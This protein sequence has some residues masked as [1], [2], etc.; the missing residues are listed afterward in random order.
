MSATQL[1]PVIAIRDLEVSVGSRRLLRIPELR[2][3]PG[4]HIAIVGPNGAG[5][6]SLLRVLGGSLAASQGHVVVLGR[7]LTQTGAAGMSRGEWR[8]LRAEVGQVMQGLHLVPRLS[9]LE[10][11]VLGALA[12]PGAMP[13]WRSWTRL[14]PAPLVD[15]ALQALAALGLLEQAHT[16][17]DRLS[18]GERQKL[19]LVRLR[20][21]HPRLVLADEPTSSL[22]PSAT[23]E[24]CRFLCAT[25]DGATLLSVV[26]NPDLIPLLADRVIALAGGEIVFDLPTHALTKQ[27][28]QSLYADAT[29]TS[30]LALA[31]RELAGR[32]SG[33]KQRPTATVVDAEAEGPGRSCPLHYQYG[34]DVFKAAINEELT[35]LDVLYVVGGLYG[36]AL[37]LDEV[38]RLFSGETGRKRLVFN[39]DFHWFDVDPATFARVQNAVLAH[40]ALRGNVETELA[41]ENPSDDAGCGCAYPEWVGDDVVLRSN[42]IL[43]SLRGATTSEQ[44]H[45]LAALPM[46]ALASV[47]SARIGIV[48]GDAQSL[49]GWGF[50]QEHLA[51]APHRELVRDW[52]DRAGVDLFA[53]THTCLPVFQEVQLANRAKPAWVLNNGAAGMPN[54]RG[55]A[56]GLLTRIANRPF[57][58]PECRLGIE[59]HGVFMDALAINIDTAQAQ[60]HF[61]AQWPKGSDAH[62][63]YFS[64]IQGGP[65]Y[66]ADQ[67]IRTEKPPCSPS[68]EAPASTTSPA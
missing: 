12:R 16:R 2:V 4:E 68:S 29:V 51:D 62:A 24:A 34:P 40:K 1:D 35:D 47:G 21:Q 23:Q 64:R 6:S 17:T 39:G 33:S 18:G 55:D 26:H 45:A 66:A 50:A 60:Q 56:A 43:R 28:L 38:L 58:G 37:A 20:M 48:H 9:A 8:G 10:N 46:W 15:E 19:S 3:G 31:D 14:Y 25:A 49:A 22:D 13:L 67:V 52:F 59:Q 53:S 42:R 41:E 7:D 65:D 54:F 61:L 32:D 44:R 5:K 57:V 36:N 11:V 30:S 27:H 63:S